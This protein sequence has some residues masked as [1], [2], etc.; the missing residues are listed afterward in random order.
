MKAPARAIRPGFRAALCGMAVAAF[1]AGGRAALTS[2]P[3]SAA[4][5]LAGQ[6][7]ALPGGGRSRRR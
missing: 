7:K 1:A 4:K 5:Q 2:L 6:M 3:G